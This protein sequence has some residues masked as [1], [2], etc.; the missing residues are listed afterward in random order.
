MSKKKIALIVVILLLVLIGAV[1]IIV[2][3]NNSNDKVR[4]ITSTIG[5]IS[6]SLAVTLNLTFNITIN[7]NT[8]KTV[9]KEVTKISEKYQISID[10]YKKEIT[11]IKEKYDIELTQ[12][13]NDIIQYQNKTDVLTTMVTNFQ[14]TVVYNGKENPDKE[15]MAEV[16]KVFKPF[17]DVLTSEFNFSNAQPGN[18]IDGLEI[19]L[20]HMASPKYYFKDQK[21]NQL[22]LDLC[23]Q[24]KIFSDKFLCHETTDGNGNFVSTYIVYD[25]EKRHKIK[26]H[27]YDEI[28]KKRN[29]LGELHK[30]FIDMVNVYRDMKIRWTEIK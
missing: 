4:N 23:T 10:E 5:T 12:Y 18:F 27:S 28:E 30:S 9:N 29:E 11:N 2:A 21:L 22:Y 7:N 3:F 8:T 14:T 16:D 25:R 13:K 15:T 26:N 24:S 19:F 17:D 6:I 1:L 20:E